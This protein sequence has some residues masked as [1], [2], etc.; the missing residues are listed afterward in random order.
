MRL[1]FEDDYDKAVAKKSH[2]WE[3]SKAIL[4]YLR[5]NRVF[6]PDV[7]VVHGSRLL[8]KSP[9]KL[10]DDIW[11]VYEQ[12][13][14]A[15]MHLGMLAWSSYCVEKLTDK[16]PDSKRVKRIYA[17]F[18]EATGDYADALTLYKEILQEAPESTFARRRIIAMKRAQGRTIEAIEAANKHLETFQMDKEV[19]HELTELYIQEGQLTKAAYTLEDVLLQD[20]R[21]MYTVLSYAEL[22]FSIGQDYDLARKYF[23]LAC[24]IDETSTRALWGLFWCNQQLHKKDQGSDKMLQLQTMTVQRLRNVYKDLKHVHS[25]KIMLQLLDQELLATSNSAA[26]PK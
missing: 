2:S 21:N 26:A 5:V 17:L 20:P 8:A 3:D 7:A 10:G 18:R 11:A 4:E 14:F 16:F 6:Q 25:T 12:V 13:C 24:E 22:I 23:C 15:S 9:G 1:Q 19:W